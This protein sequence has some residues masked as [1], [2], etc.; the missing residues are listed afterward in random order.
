[1]HM[2]TM[3]TVDL[4]FALLTETDEEIPTLGGVTRMI[5]NLS[6]NSGPFFGFGWGPKVLL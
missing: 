5:G 2:Q 4:A 1:M 6:D 3:K